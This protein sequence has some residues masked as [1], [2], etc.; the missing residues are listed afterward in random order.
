LRFSV[1]VQQ[2]VPG[3]FQRLL[4]AA[5]HKFFS[6]GVWNSPLPHVMSSRAQLAKEESDEELVSRF[7]KSG[8]SD[9]FAELFVRHRKRIYVACRCFFS[10]G[11]TAE[12]ATQETFLR[13]YQ[14]LRRFREGNFRGWLMRIAKNVCIDQWRKRRPEVAAEET[15]LNEVADAGALDRTC[16]LQEAAAKLRKEMELLPAEQHRCLE[17]KLQGYSYEETAARTGLPLLAVKSHLQNGR[18]TLWLKMEGTVSRVK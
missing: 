4:W 3:G 12:D 17:L 10:D 7:Q 16:H 8:D 14:N 5:S 2:G 6:H 1:I 15:E 13:A 9:C 18:R 11:G